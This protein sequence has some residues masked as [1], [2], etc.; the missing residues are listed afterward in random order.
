MK[1]IAQEYPQLL[2]IPGFTPFIY[3]A[4]IKEA[5]EDERIMTVKVWKKGT[6]INAMYSFFIAPI[7]L[8]TS[9]CIRGSVSLDNTP[10]ETV[11][12]R[13]TNSVIKHQFGNIG[14]SVSSI[15][16]GLISFVLLGVRFYDHENRGSIFSRGS[17]EIQKDTVDDSKEKD[18]HLRGTDK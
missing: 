12:Y 10:N 17:D 18:F 5:E 1:W 11:P 7:A 15:I 16:L 2:L 13:Y 8:I 9:D 3:E 14:F 6:M 4:K